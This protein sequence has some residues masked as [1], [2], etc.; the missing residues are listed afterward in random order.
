MVFF[1]REKNDSFQVIKINRQC[2]RCK[3]IVT[4]N[5]KHIF[6]DGKRYH[7]RCIEPGILNQ[8][9]GENKDLDSFNSYM[10]DKMRKKKDGKEIIS[11]L[12]KKFE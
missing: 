5:D 3:K 8:D 10:I 1:I 11:D 6:I 12:E 7:A 9:F 2:P 4:K